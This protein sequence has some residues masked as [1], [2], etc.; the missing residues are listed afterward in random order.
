MWLDELTNEQCEKVI[1]FIGP[2]QRPNEAAKILFPN[3][4]R[5]YITATRNIREYCQSKMNS[6][7]EKDRELKLKYIQM[8]AGIWTTLPSYA[9]M[10]PCGIYQQIMGD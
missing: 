2:K 8:S 1:K 4:Q 9:R 7:I 5:G 10:I 6:R 3:K